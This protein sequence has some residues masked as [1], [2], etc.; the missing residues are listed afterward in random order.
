M[1]KPFLFPKPINNETPGYVRF[2]HVSRYLRTCASRNENLLELMTFLFPEELDSLQ[3]VLEELLSCKREI[4]LLFLKSIEADIQEIYRLNA[5]DFQNFENLKSTF[6]EKPKKL[7]IRYLAGVYQS[8]PIPEGMNEE[9]AIAY[10]KKHVAKGQFR[11]AINYPDFKTL[12]IER[13]DSV[14]VRYYPPCLELHDDCLI[15]SPDGSREGTT[16]GV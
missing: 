15:P 4:P 2:E 13:D 1:T 16:I 8:L 5:S 10:I 14:N 6:S 7:I 3:E 11:C 12:Y 9:E